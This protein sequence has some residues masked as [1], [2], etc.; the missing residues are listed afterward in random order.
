MQLN[1]RQ[2]GAALITSLLVMVI[3]GGIAALIFSRTL[4]EMQHSRDDAGIVQTLML[5]RGGANGAASL[6][7]SPAVR[8]EIQSIIDNRRNTVSR[9]SFGSGSGSA[10]SAASVANDLTQVATD[11]QARANARFCSGDF[12]PSSGSATVSV[13]VY[14]TSST[15]CGSTLPNG[16]KIPDGRFV[17]GQ[18]RSGTDGTAFQTYALPFV[19]VS[20]AEQ[21]SYRR[22]VVLQGEYRIQVGRSSFAR[23]AY[24]SNRR[25]VGSTSLFFVSGEMIDGPVHSNEYL[26]YWGTPWFGG[27]VTV[28]GCVTPTTTS[29]GSTKTPGDYF[30]GSSNFIAS[31]NVATY[32]A[33]DDCPS[34]SGPNGADF[35]AD[36]VPMPTNNNA[37]RDAADNDG[38]LFTKPLSDLKL[39]ED[40]NYQYI[41]TV[42]CA[43][44]ADPSDP[45]RCDAPTTTRQF[46]YGPDLVLEDVTSGTTVTTEF[47][48]VIFSDGGVNSLGGPTRS[49]LTDPNSANPA[50]AD[51]SQITVAATGSVVVTRDL[52]Y[53]TPPCSGSATQDSSGNVTPVSC[54]DLDAQN[55]LGIYSQ[56]GDVLFGTGN[57]L[58][59]LDLTVHAVAM[60]GEGRV[61]TNNW[62]SVVNAETELRI[63]GGVIGETVAGFS[64]STG[65]YQRNVTYDQRMLNGFAPPHFPTTG[66]DNVSGVFLMSFGQ[67]EQVY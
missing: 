7:Q 19:M 44:V 9:W 50:L 65:G 62:G 1:L 2:R 52:K 16:V 14:F 13:R 36:F 10:P 51:F 59:P 28:A 45:D 42:E 54:N 46:R 41:E 64:T 27:D 26:R 34:F 57:S 15:V 4:N 29:C 31:A 21:G 40:S 39:W 18:G 30:N 43:N 17:E 61:G 5:A 37:Q 24:F 25:K 12:A 8:S 47:N 23:Y 20:E 11:L 38:L 67:R 63:L 49:T 33:T 58:T 22:N 3:V 53:A 66:P 6:L 32:C 35:A 56:E 60:S 55:V 48:G